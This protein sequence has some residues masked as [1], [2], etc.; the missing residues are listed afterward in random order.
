MRVGLSQTKNGWP[1]FWGFVH[2][3]QGKVRESH[4]HT[5]Y[6]PFGIKVYTASSILSVVRSCPNAASRGYR[7]YLWP[8]YGPCCAGRRRSTDI[9]RV[10]VG[11]RRVFHRVQ[12]IEVAKEF[13]EPVGRS[14]EIHSYRQGDSYRTGRWA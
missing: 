9:L 13:I 8:S 14:A 12:V 5:V 1:S 6:H 7:R 11:M 10:V 3:L 2:K 4:Y